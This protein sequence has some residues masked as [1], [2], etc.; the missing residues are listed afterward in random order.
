MTDFS[1]RYGP[2][3]LVTG[4]SS[5][6]GVGFA[7]LLAERGLDLVL[8]ARR[9]DR[10]DALAERLSSQHGVRVTAL[11]VD[12][13]DTGAID[14]IAAGV[15]GQDIGLVVS[16]AGFGMK[17]AHEDND[18]AA[19]ADMVQVNCQVPVQL[20]HRLIPGLKSR[21]RGGIIIT[22]SVGQTSVYNSG[23]KLAPTP[24]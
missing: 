12:L 23:K 17:G 8:V 9:K 11:E 2:V 14:R 5:G 15:A 19:M 10:L 3:A 7:E 4:A 18:P 24:Q 6:I 21:G 22:S 16:N 13:A 1:E 20:A